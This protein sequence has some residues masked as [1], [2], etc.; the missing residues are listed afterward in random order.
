M[1]KPNLNRQEVLNRQ[2]ELT[3][4]C[5]SGNFVSA[6]LLIAKHVTSKPPEGQVTFI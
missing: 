2:I 5:R 3:H 6:Q 1:F 4:T